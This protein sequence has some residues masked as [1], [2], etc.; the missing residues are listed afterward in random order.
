[1]LLTLVN[2]SLVTTISLLVSTVETLIALL[3]SAFQAV[4]VSPVVELGERAAAPGGLSSAATSDD[5]PSEVIAVFVGTGVG[6]MRSDTPD[7]WELRE[8]KAVREDSA[9]EA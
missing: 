6:G 5:E 7:A 9:A 3:S 1:M 8:G 2:Q 4:V